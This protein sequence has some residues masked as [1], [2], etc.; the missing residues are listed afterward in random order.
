M[1]KQ[2][3]SLAILAV[4]VGGIYA[5]FISWSLLQEKI[6]TKPY[7]S[8]NQVFRAPLVINLVQNVLACMV[9]TVYLSY[10]NGRKNPF[11]IGHFVLIS[12]TQSIA[13]PVGYE[14]LKHVDYLAFLLAK[15]CKLLPVMF[16]HIVVY[17]KKFPLY[18]YVVALLVTAGVI[19]FTMSGRSGKL[20]DST[21]DGQM[22][23]GM[24]QLVCSMLL[25]GFTN[26]TQD[27]VFANNKGLVTGASLMAG[28][29]LI[30]FAVTG[31]YTCLFTNQLAYASDFVA[32]HP[33]VLNDIMLF[34]LCGGLGQVFIFMTLE[35]FDSLVL[36]TVTVTRKMF[37]MLLSVVLFG[38]YL[39]YGQWLGVVMVFGGI[40]LEAWL[41]V[42]S[43]KVEKKE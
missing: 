3:G 42:Q 11:I 1:T 7:G 39:G 15:S 38:H 13:S 5:A 25:D 34:G 35:S 20:K 16:I 37:S 8:D 9:G 26:S 40:G 21:H 41:K 17:Q 23:L 10:K 36:V 28:L 24:A 32:T 14:S 29:N 43:K 2:K 6:N 27:Q 4:C 12:I 31:L 22:L 19:T 18:K 33:S 30:S